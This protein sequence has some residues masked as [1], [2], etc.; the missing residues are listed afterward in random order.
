MSTGV[1]S[2]QTTQFRSNSPQEMEYQLIVDVT[3][4]LEQSGAQG[5]QAMINALFRN[6]QMWAAFASDCLDPDNGLPRDLRARIISLSLWC[7]RHSRDV[8]H[9]DA[10]V[11]PLIDVNRAIASGLRQAI[12]GGQQTQAAPQAAPSN[13]QPT[14]EQARALAQTV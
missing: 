5:G 3:R 13:G 10:G 6:C 8:R 4:D 12:Q 9:G 7:D 2:Y 14:P 1:A 11:G